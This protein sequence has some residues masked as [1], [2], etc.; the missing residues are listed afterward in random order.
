[1]TD[2]ATIARNSAIS[3]EAKKHAYRQTQDGVV[4][5][6]VLHPHEVPDG[7]ALASLGTRYILALAEIGDDE[8]PVSRKRGDAAAK[9]N[10]HTV[11]TAPR[12]SNP[13]GGARKSWD[14]LSAQQQA[15]MR[16]S[17]PLFWKFLQEKFADAIPAGSAIKS[18]DD[19]AQIVRFH[20]DGVK[21]RS[22]FATNSL[23]RQLW[24][25]L[26]ADF[27]NWKSGAAA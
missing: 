8:Q 7:L 14:E 9:S 19:A 22:E 25:D 6:F 15:G 23:A 12:P 20:C 16:C 1:M 2:A 10:V 13:S 21:S 26:D 4:V 5:S 3:C 27:D 18:P 17:E 24:H 11:D